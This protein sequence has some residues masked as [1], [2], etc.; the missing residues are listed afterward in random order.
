MVDEEVINLGHISGVYGIKG[1][2]KVFSD[3][4]PRE[5]IF[6]YSSWLIESSDGWREYRVIGTRKQGKGLIALLEGIA[7]RNQAE[8]LVN[9]KIGIRAQQLPETEDGEYYWRDL[10]GLSVFDSEGVP[11]GK[12]SD[13]METGGHDVIVVEEERGRHLI[14]FVHGVYVLD[15]DLEAGTLTVDWRQD[16]SE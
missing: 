15:V 11:F 1:W 4:R 9:K 8:E 12:V 13:L 5:N 3:S 10:I 2:V 7:D 6:T 14:P 16:Y